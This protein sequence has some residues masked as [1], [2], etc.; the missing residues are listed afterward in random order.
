MKIAVIDDNVLTS[1]GLQH[2]LQDIIPVAEVDVCVSF[3]SMRIGESDGYAHY[4]VASRIYFEHA[5]F[6]RQHAAQTIVLVNGDMRI[7]DVRTLNVC[8]SEEQIARDM[9]RLH[10]RGHGAHGMGRP[11]A[12]PQPAVQLSRRE[13]EVALLLCRGKINKEVA[14][15]LDISVTTVISHRK[16]IMEKLNARSLADVMIY[17]VMNGLITI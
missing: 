8:Q 12:A 4:F 7:S 13:V 6:F 14:D 11:H 16:S 15:A 5:Q 10:D 3:D 2:L 9:M 17:C 1:L